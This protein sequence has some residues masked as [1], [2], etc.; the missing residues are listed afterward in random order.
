M[1]LASRE[2]KG[3]DRVPRLLAFHPSLQLGMTRTFTELVV[4]VQALKRPTP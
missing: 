3:L 1:F 2:H 4:L